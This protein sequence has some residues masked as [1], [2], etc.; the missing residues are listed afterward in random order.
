MKYRVLI[1]LLILVV[2]LLC[3]C[4]PSH[5]HT[6]AS[7]YSVDETY[8][9]HQCEC[10]EKEGYAEHSWNKGVVTTHPTTESEGVKTYTCT[11]C[12]YKK[13][14]PI[15]KL[16]ESHKHSYD[17][18]YHDEY[19]HG[20]ECVCGDKGKTYEHTWDEGVITT[21]ATDVEMGI[22]TFTCTNCDRKLTKFILSD[23]ENGLSFM[24]SVHHRISDKLSATP[25]TIEAEIYIDP[26]VTGRAGAIFGNYTGIREDLLF[27][28]YENGIPRFYYSD[29]AGNVRD[30]R[31]NNV[32]VRTG[33][34]AHIALTFDFEAGAISLYLNGSLA[35]TVPCEFDLADDITRYQFVLGG[36]NRSNNGNYFKGQIRYL[37]AYSDVRTA[38]EIAA[39]A[40]E[41][42]NLYADD[43]LV[44]YLLNENSAKKDIVDLTGNGYD[45]PIEWFDNNNVELDYE[46]SFAVVGDTQWLSRYSPAKMEKIYDWILENKDSKKISYVFGLGD[47][48]DAWNT[49]DKENE[50]IR[51]HQYISKLDG[52][53]PYSLVRGNHDESKYF[54]KYFANEAYMSQFDG[55]M[56]EGD[57]RNFYKAF[58]IGETDYLLIG[59]DYGAADAMLDWANEVVVSHPDH[60]VIVTTH[61]Y[62][63]FDGGHLNPDNV[64]SSGNI[65]TSSDVDTS[66]GEPSRGYNNGQQIWEKFVSKHPNIFLVLSGH[67]PMEDIF[68]LE[69]EGV[70]G[71]TVTQ[72]LVDPQ[73][74]DPQKNGV[75]M[76]AM[77]YFSKDGRQMEVEW[78]STDT[79]KYYK[80]M[81]QFAF[82]FSFT[83]SSHEFVDYYNEKC[84]YKECA[85]GY[86]YDE[87]SHSYNS[88]VL[89]ADGLMEYTCK[90]G[91]TR[92]TSAT[93][94]PIAIELQALLEK[95]YNGGKYFKDT[96]VEGMNTTTFFD[97][98]KLW[99]GDASN[100]ENTDGYLTLYDIIMGKY[101]DIRLDL[102]WSYYD[103]VYT[104]ANED[105]I[106]GIR[107]F[108][109]SLKEKGSSNI[110]KVTVEEQGVVLVIKLW[111]GD[112][113]AIQTTVGL[114][115][116]ITLVDRNGEML[117]IE[118]AKSDDSGFC[119]FIAP[120]KSGLIA[121]YDYLILN[122]KH[123]KLEKTVYYSE[124]DVWDGT[125]VSEGLSGSGT[126]E[127][128]YLIQSGAD[129]AYVAKVVNDAAASTAN[130]KGNY[131][132]MTKSIDLNGKELK[133][134]GYTAGKVFHGY[135]DGNNCSVRGI[136]ATQSLFGMLKDGYIKNLSTYGTV[137][138][139]EKKGVAGLV[140]YMSGATVENITNYVNVTGVQQVAGVVGWLENNTTSIAKNCVN[141]GT[142][143]ATSYQVG[144]IAGFAKGTLTDCVNF[145]DVTSTKSG[146]VG[147]IG[148]AAKDA[149]GSRSNCV[150][151]GNVSGTDYVGGCFGMINKATSDCYNYG[152]ATGTTANVGEVVGSGASYLTYTA[153]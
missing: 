97:S 91:Y 112:S 135:F 45:I 98:D 88:G 20:Y 143:Y 118:Y 66:V 5:T 137:T 75:G 22:M 63:G 152:T 51:A 1:I 126:L 86:I 128:P 38:Q 39:S 8:H 15:E 42:I 13:S 153:E 90:C 10:G 19:I 52:V 32:D 125:S 25:L 107:M 102:G 2:S 70:H 140:S 120:D 81:N 79:G 105:T 34:W 111:T 78:I 149:K 18:I 69:S 103:G 124:L 121:E 50:W 40:K 151:Y 132:K 23:R 114:Y 54:L 108:A 60:R 96:A 87:E 77:L 4:D 3:S 67:T 89:N 136:N 139:T 29:V 74:M 64:S 41:G 72:I 26:T 104:S 28:I 6:F 59:L 115:A 53:I 33:D 95:Y 94:D 116:T 31:F 46:Y 58:T 122:V 131:F 144:G 37:A 11:V 12:R 85:C 76:V 129:L 119:N 73:W 7:E 57:I 27:E 100:Y 145:G 110:T 127:D 134:G 93:N 71:N 56:V 133:I 146:Y 83:G 101:G 62:H 150:N 99:I 109:L 16:T 47:I 68:V 92:I 61:A 49:S 106:D 84:H 142:V 43:I 141:Y 14:E 113:V 30:I 35:Q 130:F 9:W 36:D 82:E 48:T 117:G 55:F 148:G 65:T 80:D 17:V 21:P 24:Q 123:D 138:A 147:G 44:S